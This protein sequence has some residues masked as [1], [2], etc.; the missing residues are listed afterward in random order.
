M[1]GASGPMRI[2]ELLNTLPAAIR[3]AVRSADRRP[4][5]PPD[6]QT[7]P[8]DTASLPL[9]PALAGKVSATRDG[10]CLILSAANPATAQILRFHGPKLA[11]AAGLAQ[12]RVR[13]ARGTALPARRPAMPPPSLP[14]GA[15]PYLQE[16]A[17]GC[18][19]DR[20]RTALERL[21]KQA[22][23]GE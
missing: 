18:D 13:V 22:S 2:S 23:Q 1:S 16:L 21:A 10:D 15:A 14:A 19:H 12:W 9:P 17:D 20:L 11:K 3:Q 6:S 5:A 4:A 8:V 7:G